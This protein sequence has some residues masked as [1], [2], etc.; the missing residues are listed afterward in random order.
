MDDFAILIGILAS[1][2]RQPKVSY[3]IMGTGGQ[4]IEDYS[5]YLQV[6]Y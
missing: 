2:E 5:T 1:R 3:I 6:V 4:S